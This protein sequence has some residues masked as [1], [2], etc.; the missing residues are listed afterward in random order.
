[1]V[2]ANALAVKLG[3]LSKE[4]AQDLKTLLQRQS[5]PVDYAIADID[6]F[7][8]HFFLDK[9]SNNN[10]ITFILP[11][12]IG[13]YKIVKDVDEVLV[14]EVLQQFEVNNA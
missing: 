3:L 8:E 13:S 5:L 2:M 14:K 7:Y 12:G 10:S 6:V 1:M 4:E 9:K 11:E